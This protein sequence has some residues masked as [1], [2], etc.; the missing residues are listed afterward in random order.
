V[1]SDAQPARIRL[2]SAR[3]WPGSVGETFAAGLSLALTPDNVQ[4]RCAADTR[5]CCGLNVTEHGRHALFCRLPA[6][7]SGGCRSLL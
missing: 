6:R 5:P 4:N 2:T 3:D 1:S 7:L